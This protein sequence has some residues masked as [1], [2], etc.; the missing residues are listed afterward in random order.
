MNLDNH[1]NRNFLEFKC[2]WQAAFQRRDLEHGM[3]G[4]LLSWSGCGGLKLKEDAFVLTAPTVSVDGKKVCGPTIKCAGIID[5]L[6]YSG[7]ATGPISLRAYLH[8]EMAADIRNHFSKPFANLSVKLAWLIIDFDENGST[9]F[10]ASHLKKPKA[11]EAVLDS[12]GGIPQISLDAQP[13]LLLSDAGNSGYIGFEFQV[14]PA[15]KKK[16]EIEFAA[17]AKERWINTWGTAK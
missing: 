11:A 3:M 2:N 4:Y 17:G 5:H 9:W 6:R 10:G 14:V 15:A 7:S 12:V 8:K 13:T 16:T 1:Q